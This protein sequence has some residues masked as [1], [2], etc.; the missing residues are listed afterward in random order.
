M[1]ITIW[2]LAYEINNIDIIADPNVS[3]F[4]LLFLNNL[5]DNKR[6]KG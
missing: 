1:E 3:R 4:L 5:Y 2:D 6:L